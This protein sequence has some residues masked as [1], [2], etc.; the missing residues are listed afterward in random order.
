M[1]LAAAGVAA[2]ALLGAFSSSRSGGASTH[3]QARHQA[4][5]EI[6][7]CW[8]QQR[9]PALTPDTARSVAG[10]CEQ[11]EADFTRRFGHRP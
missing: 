3:A 2:L 1:P 5:E 7:H 9:Q 11:A 4:R 10:M 8:A 6:R